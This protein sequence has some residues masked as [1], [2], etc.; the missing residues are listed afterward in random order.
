[1]FNLFKNKK[2]PETTVSDDAILAVADAEL[3]DITTAPDPMFAEKIMGDGI[4]FLAQED[5]AVI[6][7]PANGTLTA[8]FPTGH[9]FG[10][11]MK[12]GVELL[13]HIGIDT[14]NANGAGFSLMKAKQGLYVSAG[15]PI[16]KVNLKELEKDYYTGVMMI[17]TNTA[18]Q[19]I[20][21]KKTGSVKSGEQLN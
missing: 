7:A 5:E 17:I 18:G 4:I 11:T 9:A 21:L 1:M 12:N 2:E 20:Q 14:V 19:N 10:I 15:T 3:A 13:V 8:L 6:C 16:V